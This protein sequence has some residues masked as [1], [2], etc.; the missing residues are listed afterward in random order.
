M[1]TLLEQIAG[2]ENLLAA[3]NECSRRKKKTA[4]YQK[5]LT[6]IGEGLYSIAD[7]LTYS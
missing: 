1:T 6:N 7:L 2:F 3:Y 4:G 5:T